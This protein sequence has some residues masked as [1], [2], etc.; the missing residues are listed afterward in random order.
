MWLQGK[1]LSARC[2]EASGPWAFYRNEFIVLGD[3]LTLEHE[4]E[5]QGG[6]QDLD[7]DN[8]QLCQSVNETDVGPRTSI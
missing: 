3:G 5:M 6:L 4:R 2:R 1:M 8:G 7:L